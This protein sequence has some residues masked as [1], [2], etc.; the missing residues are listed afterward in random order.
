[1]SR[2]VSR[3]RTTYNLSKKAREVFVV[4]RSCFPHARIYVEYPYSHMLSKY[5]K[6]N[7]VP[8]D[9][10]DRHLLSHTRLHADF[11]LLDFG[12][13][14]EVD[15][16]QHFTPVRFGGVSSDEAASRFEDQKHRDDLKGR[17]CAEMG[18][19]LVR[20]KFDDVIYRQRMFELVKE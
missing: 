11:V 10:Q 3:V 7:K 13:V 5:Y 15:G 20:I 9:N 17:I 1:M 18:H 12:C 4:L 19:K 8:L 16:E 2:N 14:V 6:R